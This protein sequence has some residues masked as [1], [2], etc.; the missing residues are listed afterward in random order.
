VSAY[1]LRKA[2]YNYLNPEGRPGMKEQ[3]GGVWMP[4][5]GSRFPGAT[6]DEVTRSYARFLEVR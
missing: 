3:E 6:I 1:A 4:D 2:I 5:R